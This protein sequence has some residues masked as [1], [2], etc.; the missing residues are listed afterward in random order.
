MM[1]QNNL[2]RYVQRTLL[3]RFIIAGVIIAL[4]VAAISYTLE[5]DR[6]TRS[7]AKRIADNAA[8]IT[9]TRNQIGSL[10]NE[11][12]TAQ[13]NQTMKQIIDGLGEQRLQGDHFILLRF[14]DQDKK[15]QASSQEQGES[16]YRQLLETVEPLPPSFPK[17]D[18][19]WFQIIRFDGQLV[20]HVV[21]YLMNFE[22]MEHSWFE[23][24]YVLS[25]TTRA[26]LRGR[27]L[28]AVLIAFSIVLLTIATVY[29]LVMSLADKLSRLSHSLMQANMETLQVLGSA[30]A[31]RD[32]DTNAHNYR[33]TIIAVRLAEVVG[34]SRRDIRGLIKGAFLHDVGKIGIRDD[35]LLK[36]GKLD[37]DEYRVM[38]T[39]VDHG[40]EIVARSRWLSD[41]LEVVHGHHEQITGKGYPDALAGDDIPIGAR[42][43]AIV[44][45]FDA[46]TSRRPYKEPFSFEKTMMILEQDSGTHF[47]ATLI[48]AFKT[49]AEDIYTHIAPMEEG[50]EEE[51]DKILKKYFAGGKEN[52]DD[53]HLI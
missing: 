1:N 36:P 46:L 33:V 39:H 13:L 53:L 23:G 45:V 24:F 18:E 32:S 19:E 44:D 37:E 28:R 22:G 9:A 21:T 48:E 42:I 7:L 14:F 25:D 51:L 16:P 12:R 41:A 50:L 4:F 8:L 26:A 10:S 29:P 38:K 20:V 35:I 40:I 5:R 11:Q 47:D 15:L 34:L 2:K 49:I 3:L 6:F 31:K 27:L 30:I 43:F 52:L 17:P